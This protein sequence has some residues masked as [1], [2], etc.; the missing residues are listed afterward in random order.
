M[1]IPKTTKIQEGTMDE[2]N[3]PFVWFGEPWAQGLLRKD[4]RDVPVGKKCPLCREP[5]RAGDRGVYQTFIGN[6]RATS[7]SCYQPDGDPDDGLTY[8]QSALLTWEHYNT[9]GEP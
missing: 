7:R 8:R 3:E 5:F 6:I 1:Q 2:T 9:I 4:H